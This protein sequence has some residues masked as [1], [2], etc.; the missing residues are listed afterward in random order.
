MQELTTNTNAP[1][2]DADANT[3]IIGVLDVNPKAAWVLVADLPVTPN[4]HGHIKSRRLR[5]SSIIEFKPNDQGSG[6]FHCYGRLPDG[7]EGV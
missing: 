4:E 7:K 5:F 1:V 6:S 2:Y 3:Q